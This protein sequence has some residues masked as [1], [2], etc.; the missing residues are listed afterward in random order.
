MIV[1]QYYNVFGVKA[2][3]KVMTTYINKGGD[4]GFPLSIIK[5][6]EFILSIFRAISV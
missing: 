1:N 3:N 6:S 2:W 4:N 5:Y